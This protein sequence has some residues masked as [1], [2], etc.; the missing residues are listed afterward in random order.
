MHVQG[1]RAALTFYVLV[2]F[3]KGDGKGEAFEVGREKEGGVGE[4]WAIF[5]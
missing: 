4:L 5:E 3:P 1:K 2:P